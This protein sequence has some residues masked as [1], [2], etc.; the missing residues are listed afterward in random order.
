MKYA[1]ID[2]ETTG[3]NPGEHVVIEFA[4]ILVD[5][6]DGRRYEVGRYATKIKPTGEEISRAHPKA[7]EVNGYTPEAWADA[8]SIVDVAHK[9]SAHLKDRVLVGHNVP[10]DEALLKAH[11]SAHKIDARIGYRKVDTQVLAM[12]H[13][14]PLGL[15]RASLDTIRE[16]LGWSKDGAHTAMK[17]VEDTKRLFDLTWR[18]GPWRRLL[19]RLRLRFGLPV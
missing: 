12:E 4:C 13:L 18:M 6:K 7:L 9:I 2:T 14:F 16:F 15:K 1:F 17:D 19:L 3:L 8:P 10:F 11:I 5:E